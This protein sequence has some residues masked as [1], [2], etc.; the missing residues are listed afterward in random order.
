MPLASTV[1]EPIITQAD[2]KSDRNPGYSEA[3]SS[4]LR[5]RR[6]SLKVHC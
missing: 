5:D 3:K 1:I 4:Y 2:L 6:N